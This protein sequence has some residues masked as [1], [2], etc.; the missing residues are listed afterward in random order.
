M[1]HWSSKDDKSS[2]VA[3]MMINNK[4]PFREIL[5]ILL[6]H[7]EAKVMAGG[8]NNSFS[9]R[10]NHLVSNSFKNNSVTK[11]YLV[12]DKLKMSIIFVIAC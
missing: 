2:T 9:Q 3:N 1:I 7:T 4:R 5:L 12:N 6:H 10:M 8:R 11:V